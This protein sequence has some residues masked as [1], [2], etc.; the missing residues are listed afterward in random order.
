MA[1]FNR[2][3]KIFKQIETPTHI[4]IQI[5]PAGEFF[6]LKIGIDGVF[7]KSQ[8]VLSKSIC[9]KLITL[10]IVGCS[11][12][13]EKFPQMFRTV[14]IVKAFLVC[15]DGFIKIPNIKKSPTSKYVMINRFWLSLFFLILIQPIL[16][17]LS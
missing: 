15:C 1:V 10:I 8:I 7:Y 13:T 4:S 14:S 16:K 2:F 12:F 3:L 5:G 11:E 9:L 6:S 17:F